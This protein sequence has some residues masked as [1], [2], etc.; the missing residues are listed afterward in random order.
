MPLKPVARFS[1][2]LALALIIAVIVAM[3]TAGAWPSA[4]IAAFQRVE[5]Q[6]AAAAQPPGQTVTRLADGRW[7]ILGGEGPAGPMSTAMV[8]DPNTG[9]HTT[10]VAQPRAW[11]TATVLPDGTVLVVGGI[12]L[13][14]QVAGT[15]DIFDPTANVIVP[16]GV[17]GSLA[18]ARHSATLL[19]DGRVLIVGGIG[20]DG[21]PRNDGELWDLGFADSASASGQAQSASRLAVSN[22]VPGGLAD[23]RAD[24]RATLLPDGRVLIEGAAGEPEVFDPAASRFTRGEP[25]S[26]ESSPARL[27]GSDP[28]D[29]AVGVHESRRLVLRFT[30]PLRLDTL[31]PAT[32]SV[33]GPDGRVEVSVVGAEG[34]RLAFV[35][36]RLPLAPD[37]SY[38]LAISG[39]VDDAGQPLVMAPIA[40]TTRADDAQRRP[41][42][43]DTESWIPGA[44]AVR[45]GWRTNRP[46]S[47]WQD[48]PPLAAPSGV[49]ALA[50][51]VLRL[52]GQP[53]AGVTLEMEGRTTKTD[54]TGRFLLLLPG[55]GSGWC[56]LLIDGK[57][58]SRGNRVY[59]VFEVGHRIT[60]SQTT[61]LP[62]TIWMPRIDTARK[63]TIP[64]PTT[65]EVVV[66]TPWI[67]GLELH[68][69][70][71]TVI[72]DHD[73]AIVREVSITPIPVDRPPFPLAKN[74]DV[75]VYFTIQPGAAY[76]Y[77][78]SAY[79]GRV[80]AAART[81]PQ[82]AKSAASYDRGGAW[83]VYPN[84][85][86]G[87]PGKRVQFFHY[88]PEALGWYVYGLGTV[89]PNGA[90]VVPDPT[91]RI[92]EFTGA[93]IGGGP[94]PPADGEPPGDSCGN[95][96]D[97]VNLWTGLFELEQTD[98]Y[99]PDVIPISLTRTY[100]TRDWENHPFGKG[101]THPYAMFLFNGAAGYQEADMVLPDGAKI[102]FVRTSAG[103][104]FTDAVFQHKETET[105]S[106][107]PTA[108]YKAVMTWNGLGWDIRLKDGTVYVFGENAPLQA[109]RDRYGNTVSIIHA[110]GQSGNITRVMSPHG[111]WIEF[112]Y[113]ASNRITQAKDNIGRVWG[114]T[115]DAGGRLWK[116]TDPLTQ[117]T[118]YTYDGYDRMKTVKNRNGVVVVTNEYDETVGS[119]TFG[120]VK[121]QTHADGAVYEFTYTVVNGKS[122]QTDVKDPRGFIRR[123]TFNSDG[124]TVTETAALGTELEESR[125][126]DRTPRS[127][128]VTGVT[129]PDL[130]QTTQSHDPM[131]NVTSVTSL[132]GTPDWVRT[133]YTYEAIFNQ[134]QTVTDPLEHTKTYS[135]DSQGRLTTLTDALSHSTHYTFNNVGQILTVENPLHHVWQYEY[136]G[137]DLVRI[138]NPLNEIS[139]RFV[140]PAGRILATTS[141]GGQMTRYTYNAL[142]RIT[143]IVDAS[144]ATTSF[145]YYPEGQLETVTDARGGVNLYT[146]DSMGRLETRRDQLS[147]E[148]RFVYDKNGN[149]IQRHDRNGQITL[150][151]F[152][153]HNRLSLVTF[154]DNSTIGYTYDARGRASQIVDSLAGTIT[155][156]YDDLGRLSNETTPQ[157]SVSYTYD[158]ANRLDTMTV[159]GQPSLTYTYDDANRLTQVIQGSS[160]VLLGY[161]DAGR[162]TS[163]TLP[164]NVMAEYSY[165]DSGQI[166][167]FTYTRNSTFLGDVTYAYDSS[168]R[169][170]S[171]GGSFSRVILPAPLSTA[172]YDQANRLLQWGDSVFSYDPNG[173]LVSDG[174]TSYLWSARNQ[175]ASIGGAMTASFA[176]DAIG[177]RTSKTVGGTSVSFLYD[178][179][180]A[181][182]ELTAG[183][184]AANIVGGNGIDEVWMRSDSSGTWS[185]IV[186]GLGSLLALVDPNGVIGSQFTYEPFGRATPSG[187]P[188]TTASLYTGRESDA[189]DLYF[190]RARYFSPAHSRFLSEDPIGLGGGI[191]FYAYAHND[192]VN[193]RDP[194]GTVSIDVSGPAFRTWNDLDD[195]FLARS[196]GCDE[197]GWGCTKARIDIDWVCSPDGCGGYRPKIK[198]FGSITV[199][200]LN[201]SKGPPIAMIRNEEMKHVN[202]VFSAL[203]EEAKWAERLENTT[204]RWKWSCDLACWNFRRNSLE[205]IEHAFAAVHYTNPHPKWPSKD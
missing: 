43:P 16:L 66:K 126:S 58:A 196:G 100:R 205:N 172:S 11:H 157:G 17:D 80:S 15:V 103:V 177:R 148:E 51:Q 182:Q 167:A 46:D 102:H 77:S 109:I 52:D 94:A 114:Y 141:P 31:S 107:T 187:Q 69:P 183:T 170:I 200:M 1:I 62:Y 30:Q 82:A 97:P 162:R 185:P 93:M 202:A 154:A 75:P 22:P 44:E 178:G 3:A 87:F 189:P 159:T 78:T 195:W 146:Y 116:V 74:V 175:L 56:E 156:A 33:T 23:P 158:D 171:A 41:E 113:D 98:L 179:V 161:D 115:Y 83:L 21:E 194:S 7:L 129:G 160:T 204:Y 36:S 173:N 188:N 19:P 67:P 13:G 49:T 108:F 64:S 111:R 5:E 104:G 153:A 20:S 89:T 127:N 6:Q 135:Y 117:V 201:D 35:T 174:L 133:T 168:G 65:S 88:D 91:T 169:R 134:L 60:E 70:R 139:R 122:T 125:T 68:L 140:D 40:F 25:M 32:V 193:H 50:G 128:V 119:P 76:V 144:G 86:N 203:A 118:E 27:A 8:I 24:H 37:T 132:A 176:Y 143:S 55:L 90:Q 123:V 10:L 42:A 28:S 96:A 131:G 99:L 38:V 137:G 79:G 63:V 4:L 106:A 121:K 34:G 190:Y 14:G 18:R 59:G 152:D 47:P 198:Y 149:V 85:R 180:N 191:N 120:W 71:G 197:V 81:L 29:G 54:R 73:G 57:T 95:G 84:F 184:P 26:P 150:S 142:N 192:P 45:N 61:V 166:L 163:L 130:K 165:D 136:E 48:L 110:N 92:Y 2:A 9:R 164:N 155:R 147:Q 145:T 199:H 124:Y 112:S 186:D 53:L 105:T 138:I 72:R 101:T 151:T 12:G 181:V 39:A